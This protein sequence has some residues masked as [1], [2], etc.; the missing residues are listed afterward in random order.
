MWSI[1]AF[2]LGGYNASSNNSPV[3]FFCLGEIVMLLM[4]FLEVPAVCLFLIFIPLVKIVV[5]RVFRSA[6]S[7]GRFRILSNRSQ[8]GRAARGPTILKP[9]QVYDSQP[10]HTGRASSIDTSAEN[11]PPLSLICR[12]S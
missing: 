1:S 7:A 6:W 3:P 8:S 11:S 12:L 5:R 2:R 4:I 10:C 9:Y